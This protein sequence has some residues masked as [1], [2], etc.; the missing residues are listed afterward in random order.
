MADANLSF[1]PFTSGLMCIKEMDDE[2]LR[3]AEMPFSIPSATGQEVNLSLKYVRISPDNRAEYVK[4][5]MDYRWDDG[6]WL[7]AE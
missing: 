6:K 5:A 2:S 3:V 4:L 1:L 7:L